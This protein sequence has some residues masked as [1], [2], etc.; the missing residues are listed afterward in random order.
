MLK[1]HNRKARDVNAEEVNAEM[2]ADNPPS[3]AS[4]D[5]NDQLHDFYVGHFGDG[6]VALPLLR[7]D[8][9]R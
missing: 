6:L 3:Q 2:F 8:L 9:S 4:D 5:I 7:H 1:R